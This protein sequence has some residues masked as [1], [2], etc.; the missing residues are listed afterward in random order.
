MMENEEENSNIVEEEMINN[1]CNTIQNDEDEDYIKQS[2]DEL[3]LSKVIINNSDYIEEISVKE[4][5]A[6]QHFDIAEEI[7]K[8]P[9]N[10]QKTKD[11]NT[12]LTL[13]SNYKNTA[14][15]NATSEQSTDSSCVDYKEYP[16]SI[17]KE[18]A[19][20][21]EK[22]VLLSY[23]SDVE[24]RAKSKLKLRERN[25]APQ[26]PD[27]NAI[28][29]LDSSLKKN[30]AFVRKLRNF[31]APQ[32][33]SLMKDMSGLN[34]SKYTSEV[35]SALV[36]AKLKLND[37]PA[38]VALCS[39]M[40]N[41]Y[42]E[43]SKV[44][45]DHWAKT[46][47]LKK[48]EKIVNPSKLRVDLRFY[49][50]LITSGIFQFKEALPLL[51]NILTVLTTS[52][53]EEH[54]NIS[55][56][57]SFCKH[58]GEDYAGL[59]PKAMR[60]LSEKF[61]IAV[62]RSS[63]LP[64]E[65]QKN[66]R[67]LLKDYYGSLCKHL[68]KEHSEMQAFERKNRRILQTKGELSTERKERGE[69]LAALFQKLFNGTLNFAEA[70]D[71]DVPELPEEKSSKGDGDLLLMGGGLDS[72]DVT[73]LSIWEDEET[74]RFYTEFPNLKDYLPNFKIIKQEKT[75]VASMTEE[76]LDEDLKEEEL[77][78]DK[79]E[80]ETVAEAIE[81]YEENDNNTNSSN[82]ILLDAFLNLLPNCVN[83]E[84][85]DNAAIEFL[86]YH[87]T[88]HHRKKLVKVL[89]GVPRT[90]LDLLPFYARLVAILN[91]L[92]PDIATDLSVLL[93][94]DFKY[95]IRKKDQIN[96]ESKLKVIRFISELVKFDLYS[97]IEGLYCLK[98]LLHD[99]TH[100][101]IE[102]AC[103]ML[104]T[105]GRFF[106]R[107]P[108]THQRTKVYLEQIMRMKTGK[109]LDSRYVTMIEN[110]YYFVNPPEL[111]VTRVKE[112]PI[113][114][115]FIRHILYQDLTR[116]AE[117]PKVLDFMRRLNWRDQ[118]IFN[119]AIKC[120][121]QAWNVPYPNIKDLANLLAGLV[122]YQES[123]AAHVVDGV[124]EDI[125]IG[126]EANTK[127][128]NQ[129]RV[130]MVKYLGELYNYRMVESNDIFKILYSLIAFGVATDHDHP[131][132]WDP[133]EH[134][135]RIRLVCT[136]LDTCGQYFNHGPSKVKL[137]Y[138]FVYFQHYFWFKYS[139]P[140]W[141][142]ENPFPTNMN[143]M[144][145][146]CL[147]NLRPNIVLAEDYQQAKDT[148]EQITIKMRTKWNP[149]ISNHQNDGDDL[150]TILEAYFEDGEDGEDK[151]LQE[152][153]SFSNE[154]DDSGDEKE[155]RTMHIRREELDDAHQQPTFIDRDIDGIEDRAID[156]DLDS[157][158]NSD[159][160]APNSRCHSPDD[161]D[162]LAAFDKMVSDN[163][164]DRMR[165]NVKPQFVDIPVPLHVKTNAKKTY[166]QLQEP[167]TEQKETVNFVLMLRKGNKQQYKNVAVPTDSELALNL[168]SQEKAER[169]EMEKVKRLTLDIND[170]LEEE[171]YQDQLS[172]TQKPSMVNLNRE[173]RHKYQHPKGAPDADLIFGR[174]KIQR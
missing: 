110:A 112:R 89:F 109:T 65:K 132:P 43:F 14:K 147:T 155:D 169:V 125:R 159:N 168:R 101:H 116:P 93:K 8:I 23:I 68:L 108:D 52:D 11:E 157:D 139:S 86:M 106:F 97:K 12:E 136:L 158:D 59:L 107:S 124:L 5:S 44:L 111:P 21:N 70:L 126:L 100:H 67:S 31:T 145:R 161:D 60:I 85:I 55:I 40:H 154:E 27:D 94:H 163:L 78:E 84:M 113:M 137:D 144:F 121:T 88:K 71:E 7:D 83:R 96:I 38:A 25:H 128:L 24:Q 32:L 127:N 120:L 18:Q 81:E 56:I 141:T 66:V 4:Q 152:E 92:L 2:A 20:E 153:E 10:D 150:D 54:N 53:R 41:T 17:K 114:H 69:A 102:M 19:D 58:C 172:Q 173:R 48:D 16:D 28:A 162:F 35:A 33:D 64:P 57:L 36:E 15:E 95:H 74:Q 166:E 104:E 63:M 22:A 149:I 1:I 76:N 133:P 82:K 9:F 45:W 151:E 117:A 73:S 164:Q 46:L 143:H 3:S 130:A 37:V 122:E 34:L 30:T 49:G 105:C 165:D 135:F 146:D 119:Y 51:G 156:S 62:P 174:K 72:D 131:S 6:L 42:S 77:E 123:V 50:D 47:S 138:F 75:S 79:K 115:E 134:L 167:E 129:R 171:D 99:F 90:R 39:E 118:Q 142:V 61:N 98:V 87:N 80:E 140:V 160:Q 13:F 26:R 170:R 148:L 103:T 91:P 29:K